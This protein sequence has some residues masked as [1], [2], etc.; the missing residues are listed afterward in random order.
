MDDFKTIM[1]IKCFQESKRNILL[2]FTNIQLRDYRLY[3]KYICIHSFA[4]IF[5]LHNKTSFSLGLFMTDDVCEEEPIDRDWRRSILSPVQK[6]ALESRETGF[7]P[8][9]LQ[10]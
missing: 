9:Q 2:A 4:V 1:Q 5:H 10:H 6:L 7:K 8:Q 3:Q